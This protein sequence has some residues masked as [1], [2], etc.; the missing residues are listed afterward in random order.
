MKLK[1]TVFVMILMALLIS[2]T[3]L[4]VYADMGPK[5]S[6]RVKFSGIG[7]RVC[8]ATL[9]SER[10][11]TGPSSVWDGDPE[12]A[13]H[14]GIYEWYALPEEIWEAFV[15]YSD[16]DGYYFLQEGW[17][18]SDSEPLEWTYYPPSS[19]KVLL[20][21]PEDASFISSGIYERYAFDSYFSMSVGEGT[22]GTGEVKIEKSY[23]YTVEA[24]ALLARIVGTVLLELEVAFIFGLWHKR[25]L[26]VILCTNA[27]TQIILNVALSATAHFHGHLAFL[28]NY[29]GWEVVVVIVEAFTY[30]IL[31]NRISGVKRRKI[32]L[33][34]YAALAN[35]LSLLA[36]LWLETYIPAMF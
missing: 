6:V 13:N 21:F 3:A 30:C 5:P 8:Y 22:L 14:K 36:G 29:V 20:Y 28:L 19:F 25:Q 1:K 9:L 32:W 26:A 33:V 24:A 27:V 11:S 31:L 7:D 15:Y 2:V 17:L 18:V 4:S 35:I 12:H 10:D 23:D 16:P 34:L